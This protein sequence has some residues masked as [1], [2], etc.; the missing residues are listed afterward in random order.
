MFLD[1]TSRGPALIDR[2]GRRIDYLRISITDLC[3]LRCFYCMPR[4]GV[5]KLPQADILTYEEFLK[6]ARIAAG[7]GVRKMRITGGEPLIKRGAVKLVREIAAFPGVQTVAMTT[8]GTRL[9]KYA[10]VLK[11]AGLSRIN[12][13]LDS[14]RPDVYKRIT[15]GGDLSA[16]LRGI[17]RAIEYNFRIKLNTVLINGMNA[18]EV[19]RFIDFAR[20]KGVEVRFIERM[21]FEDPDPYVPQDHVVATLADRYSLTPLPTASGS[22]HVRAFDCDGVRVGFISPRSH[23][24]CDGCNKLRLTPNGK[25]KACLSSELNVDLR[26]ILRRPHCDADI[27]RAMSKAIAL[28]PAT[29]PW[30]ACAEMW[31]VGG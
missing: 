3:N 26:Y 29:G 16:V 27:A 25:L 8:N 12:V 23:P 24:F 21:S 7:L 13:S 5:T 9:E 22:P 2:H 1:H 31:R 28:K 14:L 20:D 4:Q 15:R 17:D 6:V 10:E 19:Y 30:T 11:A 18:D